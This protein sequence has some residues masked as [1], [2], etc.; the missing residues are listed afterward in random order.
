MF[1]VSRNVRDGKTV[2]LEYLRIRETDEHSLELIASPSG[3]MAAEFDL[4]SLTDTEVVFE[5]PLHDFPQ[6]II[7]RRGDDDK[8]LGRIEGKSGGHEI[9]VDFPM[10]R[11]TCGNLGL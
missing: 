10:T 1:A 11:T 2:G 9:A 6:R 5:S 8:L 4:V 3:Q 7:Y